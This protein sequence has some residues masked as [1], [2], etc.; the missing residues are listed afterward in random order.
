MWDLPFIQ[1]TICVMNE[2]FLG[3]QLCEDGAS[4]QYF[5]DQ[6]HTQNNGYYLHFHTAE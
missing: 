3:K 1:D 5:G 2:V 4:I 6:K